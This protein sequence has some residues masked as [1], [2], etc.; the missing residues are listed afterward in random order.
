MYQPFR[1]SV[2]AWLS[3]RLSQRVE[4]PDTTHWEL[5]ARAGSKA[6]FAFGEQ[7]TTADAVISPKR[8]LNAN[9]GRAY[10]AGII[11]V[12]G[13]AAEIARLPGG[14][15]VRLGG[16]HRNSA[17]EVAFRDPASAPSANLEMGDQFTS[18]RPIILGGDL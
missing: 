6:N 9:S 5:A 7:V 1:E 12:H 2:A 3:K 16:D 17:K 11:G 4:I 10:A 18:F 14:K 13:N 15:W 8:M